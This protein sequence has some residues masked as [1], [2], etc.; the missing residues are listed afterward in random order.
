V[1]LPF[2]S[3]VV[4]G[5]ITSKPPSKVKTGAKTGTNCPAPIFKKPKIIL[6]LTN[7]TIDQPKQFMMKRYDSLSIFF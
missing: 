4:D 6:A 5:G 1:I 7:K 3:W 2:F